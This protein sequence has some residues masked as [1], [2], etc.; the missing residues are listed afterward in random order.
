MGS[1]KFLVAMLSACSLAT[2]AE[3]NPLVLMGGSLSASLTM[4]IQAGNLCVLY[5]YDANGNR[6]T[7]TNSSISAGT[8]TWGSGS[9]GCFMWKQ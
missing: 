5:T 8:T 6:L 4:L 3:A 7:Q 1:A 9:Y 2:A